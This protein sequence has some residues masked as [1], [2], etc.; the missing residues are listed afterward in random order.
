MP[1]PIGMSTGHIYQSVVIQRAQ[2]YKWKPFKMD[3]E[4]IWDI[5]KFPNWESEGADFTWLESG[6]ACE[7]GKE[8]LGQ[9]KL[10]APD[11]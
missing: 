10:V 1:S 3:S 11:S 4:M 7:S 5:L 9:V 2:L 6:K 8:S